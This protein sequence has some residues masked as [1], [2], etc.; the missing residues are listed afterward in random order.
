MLRFVVDTVAQLS[1]TPETTE[2]MHTIPVFEK[3]FN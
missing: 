2:I 3:T 1:L